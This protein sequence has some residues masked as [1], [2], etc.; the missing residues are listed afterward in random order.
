VTYQVIVVRFQCFVPGER[1]KVIVFFVFVVNQG[2]SNLD[3]L[4]FPLVH[5]EVV[6]LETRM[7]D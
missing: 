1:N 6:K 3:P 2:F 7:K 4:R 5:V